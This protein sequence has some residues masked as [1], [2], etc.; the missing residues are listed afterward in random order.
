MAHQLYFEQAAC[1][2]AKP[3]S[4]VRL[5]VTLWTPGKTTGVGCH[6]FSSRS[7]PHLLCL[8]HWQVGF[9]TS[10]T[11]LL[12]ALFLFCLCDIFLIKY[13]LRTGSGYK[14]FI[15][16]SA[17]R[18]ERC[19]QPFHQGFLA[20][21]SLYIAFPWDLSQSGNSLILRHVLLYVLVISSYR[22]LLVHYSS[23]IFVLNM[24]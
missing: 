20:P 23:E 12:H 18:A 19:R 7:N 11:R 8:L 14:T 3:F 21:K 13:L 5:F 2:R 10:A 9:T 24:F 17:P 15:S 16:P 1:M 6:F 22:D 4:R